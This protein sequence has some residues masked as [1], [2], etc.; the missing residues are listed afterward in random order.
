MPNILA[1]FVMLFKNTTF[2]L[3]IAIPEMLMSVMSALNN[4]NWLEGHATEGYLFVAMIFWIC[5]FSM[6]MMSNS[7]E[8]KLDTDNRN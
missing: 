8:R 3:I 5:C 1:T 7:I 4:S 6:S 2:L